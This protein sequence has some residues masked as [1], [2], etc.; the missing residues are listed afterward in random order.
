[1]GD[2]FANTPI[3]DPLPQSYKWYRVVPSDTD[4]WINGDHDV[5]TVLVLADVNGG[6]VRWVDADGDINPIGQKPANAGMGVGSGF[7]HR[8]EGSFLRVLATGTTT[9]GNAKVYVGVPKLR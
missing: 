9:T 3:G 4:G 2:P 8:L 1:M 7:P 5:G 6:T